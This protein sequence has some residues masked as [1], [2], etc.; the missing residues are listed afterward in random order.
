MSTNAVCPAC[1][2]TTTHAL[3]TVAKNGHAIYE[4]VKCGANHGAEELM[5]ATA[6]IGRRK[7]DI[8]V[9]FGAA[10]TAIS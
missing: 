8:P 6:H 2:I 4:C 7:I 9:M 1:Q 10:K 3:M 5:H